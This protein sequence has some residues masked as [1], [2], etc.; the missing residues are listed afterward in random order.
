MSHKHIRTVGG[1]AAPFRAYI[2]RTPGVDSPEPIT[3][4]TF[5]LERVGGDSLGGFTGAAAV[6]PADGVVEFWPSEAQM[7]VPVGSYR[8]RFKCVLPGTDVYYYTLWEPVEF[9]A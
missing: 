1:N 8:W 9:K 7:T 3:S 4:A 6:V 2:D 5:E